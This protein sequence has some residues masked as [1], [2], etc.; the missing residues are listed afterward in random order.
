M[1]DRRKSINAIPKFINPLDESDARLE[2]RLQQEL[3][4]DSLD[5]HPTAIPYEYI[6]ANIQGLSNDSNIL[7]EYPEL[8]RNYPDY[9][10]LTPAYKL[11]FCGYTPGEQLKSFF[12]PSSR[13]FIGRRAKRWWDEDKVVTYTGAFT[14]I[15]AF[16]GF[17]VL[18]I[19]FLVSIYQ[20]IYKA[21][22]TYVLDD[23]GDLTDDQRNEYDA[24]IKRLD[25]LV[26]N[27]LTRY[28]NLILSGIP[29]I[30]ILINIYKRTTLPRQGVMITNFKSGEVVKSESKK[31][32]KIVPVV[33]AIP[34]GTMISP[35]IPTIVQINPSA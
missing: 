13:N 15:S 33:S 8:S 32:A 26:N 1:G 12:N 19:T 9:Y 11:S 34:R 24:R 31:N 17:I 14:K 22:V 35:S 20:I 28:I 7:K 27:T 21:K 23:T 25:N 29:T 10:K 30:I 16:A 4:I 6:G 5:Q 18:L 3:K 2:H